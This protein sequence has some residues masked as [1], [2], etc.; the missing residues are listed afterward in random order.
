MIFF[1]RR[2]AASVLQLIVLSIALFLFFRILPGD[3][4]TLQLNDPLLSRKSV[5]ALPAVALARAP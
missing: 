3:F 1:L 2:S 4:Y 5:E